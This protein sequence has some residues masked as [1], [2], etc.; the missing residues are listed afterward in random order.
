MMEG[1]TKSNL[2]GPKERTDVQ[3]RVGMNITTL[4]E[5]LTKET[6]RA[7]GSS[8][9]TN[10]DKGAMPTLIC[11]TV[12]NEDNH[13]IVGSVRTGNGDELEKVLMDEN[14][15]GVVVPKETNEHE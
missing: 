2:N 5:K 1:L 8:R 6:D 12:R 3:R 9:C 10:C 4:A 15:C 7:E 14:S 13:A 11:L